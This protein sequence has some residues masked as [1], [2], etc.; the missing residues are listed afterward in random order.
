VAFGPGRGAPPRCPTDASRGA[1]ARRPRGGGRRRACDRVESPLLCDRSLDFVRH[2]EAAGR[3]PSRSVSA[4]PDAHAAT[5]ATPVEQVPPRW[6]PRGHRGTPCRAGTPSVAATWPP[7]RPLSSRYPLGGRHA[8]TEAPPVE[9]VPPRW[10]P[11]GH[12]GTPC[13]AGTPSVAATWPPIEGTW[14]RSPWMADRGA[15]IGQIE[16]S[17]ATAA[18]KTLDSLT[19]QPRA[20]SVSM[21]VAGSRGRGSRS[22]TKSSART[23]ASATTAGAT[24]MRSRHADPTRRDREEGRQSRAAGVGTSAGAKRQETWRV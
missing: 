6:P 2:P 12:R 22:P 9:Q 24:W 11:R 23:G 4:L 10:P 16:G 1:L 17:F 14:R 7:R 21:V 8:A 18:E 15:R 19:R 13:R 20:P 5:E 3:D